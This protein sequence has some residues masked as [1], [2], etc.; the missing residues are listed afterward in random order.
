M[1]AIE[2][3]LAV[4]VDGREDVVVGQVPAAVVRVVGDEDVARPELVDAEEVER[5][6][7]RQGRGEHELRDADRQRRQA[8]LGVDDRGVALVR[9]VEDRRRGRARDVGRH[10]PAHRLHRPA[11][12]LGGD[13]I[14]GDVGGQTTPVA[15]QFD[16]IDVHR[17]SPWR[18]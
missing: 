10:L 6:A 15:C 14:D 7:H 11:D 4:D 12:D 5:E 17:K 13:G 9:L 2:H 8:A 3:E 16:Q 18:S 1:L